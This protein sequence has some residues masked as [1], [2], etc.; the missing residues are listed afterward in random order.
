MN[1]VYRL[2]RLSVPMFLT[3]AMLTPTMASVPARIGPYRLQ[4]Y[5]EPAVIPVGKARI[6][7]DVSDE[8][9]KPVEGV[10]I[11]SLVQMPSMSMGEKETPAQPVPGRSGSYIVDASF[12][13]AGRFDASLSIRGPLG[14]ATGKVSLETGQDTGGPG[15]EASGFSFGS[16][17]PW[18]LGAMAVLAIGFVLFRMRR[19]GQRISVQPLRNR[20]VIGGI[21]LL[22]LA[23]SVSRWAINRWRRPG[24]MTP[25]QAQSMEMNT[26]APPGVAMVTLS[27]AVRGAIESTLSYPGQAIAYNEQ[28]VIVRSEGWL[29]AMPF[30][31]GQRVRE[32]EVVA[33]L[34]ISDLQA[35]AELGRM[36]AELR[37]R[38]EALDGAEAEVEAARQER[39]GAEADLASKQSMIAAAEAD[40]E[41]WQQQNARNKTLRDKGAISAEE[42]QREFAM[43][44]QAESR[45]EQARAEMRAAQAMI[46]R[47]DAMVTAAEKKRQQM[48]SDVGAAEAA[49]RSAE[50]R[51]GYEA[52]HNT[53]STTDPG[54][55]RV[56]IRAHLAGVVTARPVGL[57]QH[58]GPGAS[59]MKI[60]QTDPIRLQANVAE[61]DLSRIKLGSR[62]SIAGRDPGG[63][64]FTARVTS[65][66]PTVDPST[67]TGIVEAV[68]PNRDM[69]FMPGQYLQLQ[70]STGI[71][72]DALR[73]PLAAVRSQAE[74]GSGLLASGASHYVWVAEKSVE[75]GRYTVRPAAVTTGVSDGGHIQ[76]VAGLEPGQMVVTSGADYLKR[77]DTVAVSGEREAEQ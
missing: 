54:H 45:L 2:I 27:E 18:V 60:V 12:G 25:I 38:N 74:A 11:R 37:G 53:S 7:I 49:V 20:E 71:V 66:S 75:P 51:A 65:V 33:V 67:R 70:I 44:Q 15:E 21:L 77:G 13:M 8:S 68:V 58:V 47:A 1:V 42:F 56:E 30:Y 16:L 57:G 28:D 48:T 17:M 41:F 19:T 36:R 76:I 22:V 73:V 24:S 62:V 31:V 23:F 35:F 34:D 4:I 32:G 29:S 43:A 52:P 72:E 59:I 69:R 39:A 26:P 14:D 64:P 61:A 10:E 3:G 50:A 46:R 9:G 6:R 40:R 5:T 63:S 55:G